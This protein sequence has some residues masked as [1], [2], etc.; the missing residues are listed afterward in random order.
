MIEFSTDVFTDWNAVQAAL[1]DTTDGAI[2]TTATD[3]TITFF[4]V[5]ATELAANHVNDFL[6]V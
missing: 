4:G 5:T 2:M 3:D 6:F 1:S